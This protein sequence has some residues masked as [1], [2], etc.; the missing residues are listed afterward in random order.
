MNDIADTVSRTPEIGEVVAGTG[1]VR[2]FRYAAKEGRGKSGGARVIYL[3]VIKK[4]V[5]HLIDIF[6]KNEKTNLTKAEK[7]TI[8]KL[9]QVLKGE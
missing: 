3:A 6:G 7:N 8:A 5:I 9:S 2:K 4:G 1:D